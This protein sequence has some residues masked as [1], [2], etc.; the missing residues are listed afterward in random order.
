MVSRTGGQRQQNRKQGWVMDFSG[1]NDFTDGKTGFSWS[2]GKRIF[3]ER[4]WRCGE[5]DEG[6]RQGRK[7]EKMG[8]I[9]KG[10]MDFG[11]KTAG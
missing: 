2:V 6:Q 10:R 11:M 3:G 5:G 9:Y 8:R 4:M 7:R 1:T